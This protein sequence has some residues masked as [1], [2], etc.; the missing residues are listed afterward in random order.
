MFTTVFIVVIVGL[1]ALV[2]SMPARDHYGHR[3][4]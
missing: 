2:F 3:L 4:R 1:L